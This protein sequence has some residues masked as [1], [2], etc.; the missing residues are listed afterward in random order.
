MELAHAWVDVIEIAGWLT[1]SILLTFVLVLQNKGIYDSRWIRVAESLQHVVYV[2]IAGTAIY[3]S[4]YG[5]YVYTWDILLWIGG[6]AVIDAAMT[7][8]GQPKGMP[9]IVRPTA[10][11]GPPRMLSIGRRGCR[12]DRSGWDWAR[13]WRRSG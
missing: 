10:S 8:E 5:Y 11:I 12:R 3:W 4:F 1:V 9:R 2:I 13:H 7:P 6:F